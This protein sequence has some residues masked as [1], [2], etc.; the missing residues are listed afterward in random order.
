MITREI[1]L[2]RFSLHDF[3]IAACRHVFKAGLIGFLFIFSLAL[4]APVFQA[5]AQESSFVETV[6]QSGFI[7]V[8]KLKALNSATAT[9]ARDANSAVFTVEQVLEALPPVGNP[10]GQDVTV[11][12]RDSQKFKPG[13]R[14][15]LFTYVQSAGAT[16]GLVEVASEAAENAADVQT[17][18][19]AA[20]QTIADRAL[21]ARLTSAELVVVGTFGE[22]KPTEAARN[23]E[24]EHDPLWWRAPIRVQSVEKGEAP[25]GSVYANFATNV[26]YLWALAPKPKAGQYGIYLLQPDTEKRFRVSGLFLI[27]PQDALPVSDLERVQRI[28][29]EPR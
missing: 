6:N 25:K 5:Q 3:P 19:R 21:A 8:G 18:I 4:M 22:A 16:L 2:C 28:L 10:T 17:R 7:F 13:D 27:D 9:A 24:S 20:R 29:K 15:I 11:R 26:D 14:V 12:L 23:P 1:R